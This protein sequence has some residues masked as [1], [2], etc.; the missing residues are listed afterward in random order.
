MI[1]LF[2]IKKQRKWKLSSM[3]ELLIRVGIRYGFVHTTSSNLEGIAIWF[4]SN[5]SKITTWMG[6]LSGGFHY[7]FKL[8][9]K[10]I[11]RQKKFYKFLYSKHKKLMSVPHWYLSLI[12]VN[13]EYQNMGF[14]RVLFNR[15]FASIE[16]QCTPFFLD[17]NNE[18]NIPIYRRFGFDILEEFDIPGTNLVNWA[19]IRDKK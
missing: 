10:A 7:F 8:G 18:N 14:S 3:M 9:R 15:M 5:R 11:K 6:L 4:P 17:T 13:P 2:P 19:M 12:A 1:Y 16:K